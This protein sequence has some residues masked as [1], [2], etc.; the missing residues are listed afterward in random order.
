MHAEHGYVLD[1]TEPTEGAAESEFG[2]RLLISAQQS[3]IYLVVI[4]TDETW[5]GRWTEG[6]RA[7]EVRFKS[8]DARQLIE[9][10]LRATGLQH[11]L[12]LLTA[13]D[14]AEI[15]K[16]SPKA[17]D[18]R[19][20]ALLIADPADRSADQIAAEYGDWRDWI[21][22]SLPGDLDPRVLMWSCA[23]CDGGTQKSILTMAEN[24]RKHLGENR[25]DREI[26]LDPPASRRLEAAC[27]KVDGDIALL[28]PGQHGLAQA[29]CRHLWAE[30]VGQREVLTH[31]L[32]EQVTTLPLADTY[33]IVR[34]M[35]DLVIRYRDDRLLAALRD[36]L[37]GKRRALAVEVFGVAVLDAHFGAH[38]RGRLYAWMRYSPSQDLIDV[39]AE[40]CGGQFGILEPDM[41]LTRL[42]L[43]A[44][45]ARP[46][47]RALGEA[48]A[49][50]AIRHPVKVFGAIKNWLSAPSSNWAAI[51]A[52]LELAAHRD[53]AR[54]LCEK[55][56]STDDPN[57]MDT[58]IS[59]FHCALDNPD[60]R[61][62]AL[63]LI[64]SWGNDAQQG[65][66]DREITTD[67]LGRALA[68]CYRDVMSRF[69]EAIDFKRYWG[70]VLE[71]AI[72][73]AWHVD[74]TVTVE[75][76]NCAESRCLPPGSPAVRS[77][78]AHLMTGLDEVPLHG[79]AALRS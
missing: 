43:A 6:A 18:A 20:L 52:F 19:R 10:Q 29:V 47:S 26:L 15:W 55:A 72:H 40:V 53:G 14:F 23:F 4:T 31:W 37:T 41:A 7:A 79:L 9:H 24:L 13:D 27:I 57:A 34:A 21:N 1:L 5:A 38:V 45:K 25:S 64:K 49:R 30:Y 76:F 46:G 22:Q 51:N 67:I 70:H 11:R 54:A 78:R 35:L 48:F 44:Q 32:N 71:I 63:A 39:V 33:K 66:L 17:E 75:G 68:P 62:R 77:D 42:R 60:S 58:I 56:S 12:P 69:P 59:Y 61:E 74:G 2:T 73:T 16:S 36:S 28:S 50:L 3:A 8:P 65:V